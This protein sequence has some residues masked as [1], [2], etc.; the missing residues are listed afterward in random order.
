[1]F[2]TLHPDQISQALTTEMLEALSPED[3]KQLEAA[4]VVLP[5]PEVPP[6]EISDAS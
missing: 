3:I 6:E 5:T 1:M 4:G 2:R